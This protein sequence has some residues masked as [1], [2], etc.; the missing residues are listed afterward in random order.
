MKGM[1]DSYKFALQSTVL[2]GPT[3]FAPI[4]KETMKIAQI[5]KEN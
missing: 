4:I 5:A 1:M 2:S 3:L